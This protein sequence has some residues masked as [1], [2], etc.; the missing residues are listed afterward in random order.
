MVFG[1]HAHEMDGTLNQHDSPPTL[2]T[3]TN[4]QSATGGA[5]F[6]KKKYT[7]SSSKTEDGAI[8]N[9]RRVRAMGQGHTTIYS[10]ICDHCGGVAWSHRSNVRTCSAVCQIDIKPGIG[11][12][13]KNPR[14]NGGKYTDERGY[15]QLSGMWDHPGHHPSRG[16]RPE[17]RVVMESMI[18]R[19]LVASESVHHRNG[20]RHDNRPSNLELWTKAQPGGQ[21]VSDLVDYVADHQEDA[22]RAKL[23]VK[24]AVR[25][26][27]ARLAKDG[28][29][30]VIPNSEPAPLLFNEGAE[31][32]L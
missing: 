30:S 2:N 28:T 25:A 27:L 23:A 29:L 24:D 6:P 31:C 21:R 9:I 10:Y 14:W 8:D 20:I 15:V 26:V 32:G 18:G 4:K 11:H 1:R 12:G 19:S 13:R 3:E 16:T 17:H 7:Y 5:L 22:I